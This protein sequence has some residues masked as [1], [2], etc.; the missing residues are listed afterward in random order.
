ELPMSDKKRG[1]LRAAFAGLIALLAGIGLARFAYG[2]LLP[3]LINAG[4]FSQSEAAYIGAANL[5]GYLFGAL[6]GAPLAQ[7]FGSAAALRG[8]ALAVAASFFL[9][10][11]PQPFLL[12]SLWR[13]ISGVAGGVLMV[14]GAPSALAFA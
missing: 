6:L 10:A 4:W 8:M 1:W 5:A 12:F 3:A 9:C 13:F 2:P 11:A 14:V 7:R